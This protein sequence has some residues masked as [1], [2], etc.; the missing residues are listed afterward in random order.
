MR[1]DE[2]IEANKKNYEVLKMR[3]GK[4]MLFREIAERLHISVG[5]A[6][7]R[8]QRIKLKQISLY[9]D[10]I[11][12]VTGEPGWPEKIKKLLTFYYDLVQVAAYLES[13]Y[14]EILDEFRAGEPSTTVDFLPYREISR[15]QQR[16]LENQ[17]VKAKD[18][19]KKTFNKIGEA[20]GLT[21]TKTKVLYQN[22]YHEKI[23]EAVKIIQPSVDI[24]LLAYLYSTASRA[25]DRWKIMVRDYG[26]MIP[27][28]LD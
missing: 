9:V 1:Y 25:S 3:E 19:D 12:E 28:L 22:Y 15:E 14:K 6:R 23:M 18:T 4:G 26:N 2:F 8:Y 11:E 24:D 17:I 5:S 27:E 13:K 10:Y 20:F 16:C 21:V 7:E